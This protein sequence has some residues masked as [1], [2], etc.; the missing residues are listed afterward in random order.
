VP[1]LTTGGGDGTFSVARTFPVDG[2]G[3]PGPVSIVAWLIDDQDCKMDL[4]VVHLTSGV[5]SV[6]LNNC[7]VIN[8]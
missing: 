1:D 6:L 3:V 8:V 7:A 4:A 2:A 5:V